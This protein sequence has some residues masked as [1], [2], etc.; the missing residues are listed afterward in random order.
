MTTPDKSRPMQRRGA[1]FW[2]A[3]LLI[4]AVLASA[5]GGRRNATPTG[6]E[7]LA[8][9]LPAGWTPLTG[10]SGE[11]AFQ[12]ITID[13]DKDNEWLLLFRYDSPEGATVGPIGGI[14][15]DVQQNSD[16]IQSGRCHPVPLPADGLFCSVPPVARLD[17][18]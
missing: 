18:R 11:N 7:I 14:I 10:S 5:C 2:V 13:G 15:Y 1:P 9:Y 3:V 4:V 8:Q 16:L 17:A 6:G 12:P